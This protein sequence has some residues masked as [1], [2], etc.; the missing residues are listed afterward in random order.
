M[1]KFHNLKTQDCV[2]VW[3]WKFYK[4]LNFNGQMHSYLILHIVIYVLGLFLL[5]K[6]LLNTRCKQG[7]NY[8]ALLQPSQLTKHSE[9]RSKDFHFC[10][11]PFQ[12][13]MPAAK[14]PTAIIN[15]STR[16][17]DIQTVHEWDSVTAK[18][19]DMKLVQCW[20]TTSHTGTNSI[21]IP[22]T[23]ILFK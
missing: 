2:K 9:I 12:F 23:C 1:N 19:N 20:E 3:C 13:L 7:L 8:R 10:Y 18:R 16:A 15:K 5:T 17:I 14:H 4:I 22:L 11:L 21:R 6:T